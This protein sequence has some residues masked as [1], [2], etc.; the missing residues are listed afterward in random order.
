MN[1]EIY[2]VTSGCYS[3]YHI[4]T[5]FMDKDKAK[6]FVEAYNSHKTSKYYDDYEIETYK[7]SDID[8]QTIGDN[9]FYDVQVSRRGACYVGLA[10][11]GYAFETNEDVGKV[12]EYIAGAQE[13]YRVIVLAKDAEHAK[14][15][16]QDKIAQY[17]AEKEGL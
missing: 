1:N 9:A 15:I 4:V 11:L 17:K 12:I 7:V 5:V 14:R 16:A 13:G 8:V 2:I 10:E 6:A 3:D